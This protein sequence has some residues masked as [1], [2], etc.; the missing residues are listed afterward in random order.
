L[1]LVGRQLPLFFKGFFT[2]TGDKNPEHR[3]Q[4]PFRFQA[5]LDC[6]FCNSHLCGG[7]CISVAIFTVFGSNDRKKQRAEPIFSQSKSLLAHRFALGWK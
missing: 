6:L 3:L 2:F 5:V 1:S 4:N 7:L